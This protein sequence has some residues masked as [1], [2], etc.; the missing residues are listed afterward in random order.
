M[1]GALHGRDVVLRSVTVDVIILHC[2][3]H[4]VMVGTLHWSKGCGSSIWRA[5]P[6]ACQRKVVRSSWPLLR[7][8]D[9]IVGLKQTKNNQE[10]VGERG[11]SWSSVGPVK[12]D[13]SYDGGCCRFFVFFSFNCCFYCYCYYW[14]TALMMTD[15]PFRFP[16][17]SSNL[18]GCWCWSW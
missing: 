15:A 7:Q 12:V 8:I 14:W 3:L 13:P 2:H 18:I 16:D 11:T 17:N 5:W 10:L 1:I 6:G 4:N 9:C